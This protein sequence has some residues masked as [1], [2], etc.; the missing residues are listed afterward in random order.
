MTKPIAKELYGYL[1]HFNP[2]MGKWAAIPRG[3]E[4]AYFNGTCTS[5]DGI[6]YDT[7]NNILIDKVLAH[8]RGENFG[9]T[10]Y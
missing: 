1:F 3:K 5:A 2:Y 6:I 4:M 9:E 7:S 8:E 10:S